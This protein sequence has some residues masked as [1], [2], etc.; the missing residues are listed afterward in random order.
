MAQIIRITS[1]ALQQTIRRLLPSQQGFG[2]DLQASNVIQPIIDLT[3][4][5][6]GSETRQDLQTAFSFGSV[7][8]FSA[9]NS[10]E[11]IANTP[12][13]YRVL[14][15]IGVTND[16][17]NAVS[18]EISINDGSSTKQ[19][20]EL[21]ANAASTSALTSETLDITVFL[22]AGDTLRATSSETTVYVRGCS[23]QIADVNGNLQNPSG[24][25]PQ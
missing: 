8:E 23:W 9:R 17:N 15:G 25:T 24:F 12:G 20:Y 1:E 11:T 7:T 10:T 5:A 2:E 16:N 14:A 13:F 4:S 19:L 18:A 22:R 21:V 3:P 6:E